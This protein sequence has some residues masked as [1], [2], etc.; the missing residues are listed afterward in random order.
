MFLL[1]IIWIDKNKYGWYISNGAMG[2][3]GYGRIFRFYQRFCKL[4]F[5]NSN[6][7]LSSMF[8]GWSWQR[9]LQQLSL[10]KRM[11]RRI[12]RWKVTSLMRFVSSN[13]KIWRSLWKLKAKMSLFHLRDSNNKTLVM[14]W[15]TPDF[16]GALPPREAERLFLVSLIGEKIIINRAIFRE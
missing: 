16:Y 14:I 5:S 6:P 4:V 2:P 15:T 10:L 8:L 12:C 11:V 7:H 3:T 1:I 13:N 9:L